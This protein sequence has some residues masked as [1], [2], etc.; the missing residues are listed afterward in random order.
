MSRCTVCAG[1]LQHSFNTDD[2]ISVYRC[3]GEDSWNDKGRYFIFAAG[4]ILEVEPLKKGRNSWGYTVVDTENRRAKQESDKI[5]ADIETRQRLFR[6]QV[7]D[8]YDTAYYREKYDKSD[9]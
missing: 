4:Q 7:A 5:N 3:G 6:K 2:G 8:M 9:D 1:Y